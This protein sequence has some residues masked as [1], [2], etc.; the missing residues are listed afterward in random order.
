MSFDFIKREEWTMYYGILDITVSFYFISSGENYTP[1]AA[2]LNDYF[3]FEQLNLRIQK[4][5][6]FM[7]AF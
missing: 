4:D 7:V 6:F 5:S 3:C 1:L 2:S